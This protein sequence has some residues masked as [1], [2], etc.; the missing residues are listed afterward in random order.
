MTKNFVQVSFAHF[1]DCRLG[2]FDSEKKL[3]RLGMLHP[4][5][6]REEKHTF[7]MFQRKK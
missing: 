3:R 5:D 4:N 1:R 7:V 6:A 2:I